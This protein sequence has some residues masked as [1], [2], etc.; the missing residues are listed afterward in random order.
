MGYIEDKRFAHL[1]IQIELLVAQYG[2]APVQAILAQIDETTVRKRI[3]HIAAERR[4]EMN[5]LREA[6][7]TFREIGYL[8]GTSGERVRLLLLDYQAENQAR[9]SESDHQDAQREQR[10]ARRKYA[11]E[12]RQTGKT[13]RE[14]GEELGITWQGAKVLCRTYQ[15]NLQNIGVED[16]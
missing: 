10:L 14:I 3:A 13:Y 4:E 1:R 6:G 12:Q 11:Y 7:L 16:S 9:Q 2:M 15:K 8:F 5:R